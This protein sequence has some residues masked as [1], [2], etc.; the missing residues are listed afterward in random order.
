M[1]LPHSYEVQER[2]RLME[3]QRDDLLVQRRYFILAGL[4]VGVLI[5]IWYLYKLHSQQTPPGVTLKTDPVWT[6]FVN[7]MLIL[8]AS[9]FQFSLIHKGFLLVM[10]FFRRR[11]QG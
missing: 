9:V 11:N 6:Q 8:F 10:K 7:I 1:L 4:V 3:K 5:S 2:S